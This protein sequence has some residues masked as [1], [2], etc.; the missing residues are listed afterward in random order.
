MDEY[1]SY[2]DQT[3]AEYRQ[4]V[5]ELNAEVFAARQALF[6]QDVEWRNAF[7]ASES[8]K[9]NLNTQVTLLKAEIV[10]LKTG[11]EVLHNSLLSH[12]D[13]IKVLQSEYERVR[14]NP[15]YEI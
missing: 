7:E 3:I 1:M 2:P 5:E 12:M 10:E 8:D 4:R 9:M 11:N 6:T 14:G 13:F 15:R